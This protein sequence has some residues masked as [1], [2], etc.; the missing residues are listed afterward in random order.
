MLLSDGNAVDWVKSFKFLSLHINDELKW[1]IQ[2]DTVVKNKPQFLFN[3]RRLKIFGLS[4]KALKLF[5][6]HNKE[7]PAGLYHRL[8]RQLLRSQP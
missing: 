3:L 1:S 2:T 4:P 5:Q 6:M 8:V 7:H